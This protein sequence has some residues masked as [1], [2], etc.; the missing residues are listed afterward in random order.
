MVKITGKISDAVAWVAKAILL[1]ASCGFFLCMIWNVLARFVFNKSFMG[2][3][4]Y[5]QTCFVW[6]CFLGASLVYKQKT[7]IAILA[8]VKK[9]PPN[10]Q[11]IVSL[12]VEFIA[13]VFIGFAFYLGL[14]LALSTRNTPMV[15]SH[16]SQAVLYSAMPISAL[17]MIV[18]AIHN[19]VETLA[20]FQTMKE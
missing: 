18:H 20:G 9:L 10:V 6:T 3:E 14:F 7:N 19:I 16:M 17:F 11:K 5:S 8:L 15:A 12:L 13:L 1:P 2:V 4:D